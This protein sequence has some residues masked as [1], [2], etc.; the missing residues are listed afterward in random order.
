MYPICY[1]IL[2]YLTK[3]GTHFTRAYSFYTS[4]TIHNTN[5]NILKRIT[6]YYQIAVD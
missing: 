4:F 1:C 6:E 2:N 5:N 3:G